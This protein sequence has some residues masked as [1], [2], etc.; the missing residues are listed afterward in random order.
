VTQAVEAAAPASRG[1]AAQR[2]ALIV[3]AAFFMQNLDGAIINTSL[4]QMARS[5]AVRPADLNIGI[6]AYILSTAAFV[7]LSGWIADRLG[8]K[9]VFAAAI[10]VFTLASMACGFSQDLWS[11]TAARAV[12]GLGGALMAP[13]GRMVVLRNAEKADLLAATA[14][15]TW[16]ALIAPVVGP[17]VGGFITTYVNWRWNFLLNIPLGLAGVALV[18]AFIPGGRDATRNRFDV[19]GFV[20]TSASLIALLAGLEGLTQGKALALSAGGVLVGIAV[21][22]LA[23]RHLRRHDA[24][25]LELSPLTVRTFTISTVGT[26]NLFRLTISATPFLLPLMFQLAFGLSAWLAGLYVLAYFAGNLMMKTVTTPALR[27]FGFRTVLVV[28]GALAGLSMLACGFLTPETSAA[29][30][31]A[32]LLAAGLTRSMQFT[33][34]ATLTFADI[35]AHQ[36]ASSSTLSSML[37]Q[38]SI[39]LG[40][41]VGAILLNLSQSLRGASHLALADFRLAFI[42]VGLTA[43][44]GSLLFLRLSHD[45]GAEVSGHRVR[46]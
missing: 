21:G 39:G 41:A 46:A 32:V 35:E 34:L 3:A 24:P 2:V 33:A 27:R 10:V 13:V 16:P 20:L 30:V 23:M 36:R 38:V 8:A 6:T 31:V 18:L 42:V 43:L 28:N 17:V 14:L 1:G 37:Q 40:V 7:P 4:P 22:A 26:G 12:Q 29:V 5:F 9:R 11:F 45:A 19:A 44:G 25:L 15:I